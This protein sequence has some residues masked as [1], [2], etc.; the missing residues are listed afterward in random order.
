M[1][2]VSVVCGKKSDP[3]SRNQFQASV[4]I[5][6]YLE[7]LPIAMQGNLGMVGIGVAEDIPGSICGAVINNNQLP[8]LAGLMQH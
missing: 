5:P 2:A 4:E 1:G 3:L 8:V 6:P 7:I